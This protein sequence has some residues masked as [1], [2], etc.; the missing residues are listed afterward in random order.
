M[1]I[2]KILKDMCVNYPAVAKGNDEVQVVPFSET[3]L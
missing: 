3:V 1:D 2:I